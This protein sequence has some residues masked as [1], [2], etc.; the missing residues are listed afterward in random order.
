MSAIQ[1]QTLIS[2]TPTLVEC[3]GVVSNCPFD[4]NK[5]I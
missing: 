1:E 5:E 4:G 2:L 3:G